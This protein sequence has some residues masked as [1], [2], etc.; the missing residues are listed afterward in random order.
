MDT[1]P[2][3]YATESAY[4]YK[5][6]LSQEILQ[7]FKAGYNT[8]ERLLPRLKG[9]Y[10]TVVLD[11][12]KE[13]NVKGVLSVKLDSKDTVRELPELQHNPLS[14][15]EWRLFTRLLD[16]FPEPHPVYFEWYYNTQTLHDL[17]SRTD[18]QNKAIALLGCPRVFFFFQMRGIGKRRVLFD[19]NDRGLK[20]I[21]SVFP[22]SLLVHYDAFERLP[23][24]MLRKFDI[25]FFD[26]PWYLDHFRIWLARACSLL[27]S[28]KLFM[29]LWGSLVRE[30]ASE[31]R[32][33][34][35]NKLSS[36]G[37]PKISL[38][39]S[40]LGYET[41]LFEK[42]SLANS[43][44]RLSTDWRRA[45]L[46]VASGELNHLRNSRFKRPRDIFEWSSYQFGKQ[47]LMTRQS[48]GLRRM[49]VALTSIYHDSS[50]ICKSVSRRDPL[51]NR[52][53][54]WT[55]R[56]KVFQTCRVSII[57]KA[58]SLLEKGYSPNKILKTLSDTYPNESTGLAE[59]LQIVQS[60]IMNDL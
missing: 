24:S 60:E 39:D 51:R 49:P 20:A 22:S 56:N 14:D 58:L 46:L 37:F 38:Y 21:K 26:P 19:I 33:L 53:G 50:F 44:V 40:A 5:K 57:N 28:G 15:H 32:E 10:P 3:T 48:P 54:L 59:V 9:A 4:S 16:E 36:L 25:V 35:K 34:I 17:C 30:G 18:L 1:L 29:P 55:S 6:R 45:D 52:I 27:G 47:V 12:L 11:L 23:K 7:E 43:G 31:E 2:V 8:I 42:I 41:P 13:M